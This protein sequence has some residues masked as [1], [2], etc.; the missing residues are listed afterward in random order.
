MI[1][2]V[3]PILALVVILAS[4]KTRTKPSD[5]P[6]L[7]PDSL[8][9]ADLEARDDSMEMIRALEAQSRIPFQVIADG[10][11]EPVESAEEEDAADD[12]AIWYNAS[13]PEESLVLGTD[14]KAGIYVYDLEGNMVQFRNVGRINNVDLR[15]GFIYNGK[16][17]VLVAGSNRSINCITLLFLDKET[18]E[19]SD[20]IFNIPS[21]VDEVYGLCMYRNKTTDEFHVFVNGKGG[22]LEQWNITSKN[23]VLEAELLRSI[24]LGSQPEGMVADDNYGS[25][26]LGV[27]EEGI[28]KLDTD[29]KGDTLLRL[30]PGSDN[31]NPNIVYDVEGLALFSFNNEKYLVASIQGNFSYAI[32]R[33][34][35][36]DQYIKSFVIMDGNIDGAEETDGLEAISLPLNKKY[37]HGLLVVQDGFNTKGDMAQ[38]QNFKYISLSKITGLL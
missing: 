4:C 3:L 14:K 30:L 25:V 20:S 26:Y 28:Y 38:S 29:P 23:N 37:D 18:K 35:D 31:S 36:S 5:V 13:D 32:F 6:V 10:E 19:L 9:M 2:K 21:G 33:V 16:E 12:P 1:R 11:T 24:L 17:V 34:G 15:D 27:E 8:E 22:M 7:E